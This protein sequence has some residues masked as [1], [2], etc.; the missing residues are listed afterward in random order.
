MVANFISTYGNLAILALMH[1]FFLQKRYIPIV[2]CNLFILFCYALGV[3]KVF[4]LEMSSMLNIF[5]ITMHNRRFKISSVVYIMIISIGC[6]LLALKE[7]NNDLLI[8]IYDNIYYIN[9]HINIMNDIYI[10]VALLLIVGCIPFGDWIMYLFS[11]SSSLFKVIIFITPMFLMFNILYDYSSVLDPQSYQIFGS[12]ICVYSCFCII[13]NKNLRLILVNVITYFY[14]IQII[15]LSKSYNLQFFSNWLVATFVI[16]L[17]SNTIIPIR[18][19]KYNINNIKNILVG[20]TEKILFIISMLFLLYCFVLLYFTL[21][22]TRGL[23]KVVSI[24]LF[25]SFFAKIIASISFL[26]GDSLKNDN[27]ENNT[28]LFRMIRMFIGVVFLTG[29]CVY[30][31]KILKFF[32]RP[33]LYLIIF[34]LLI[35]SVVLVV[36][37]LFNNA[38]KPK[39]LKSKTYSSF[40]V[41]FIKFLKIIILIIQSVFVDFAKS[42]K[43]KVIN[44]AIS[45]VPQKLSNILYGKHLYFYI[46]FLIE[47]IIV[48]TIECVVLQ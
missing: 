14:G 37:L 41:N 26:N 18:T 30:N 22:E 24:S 21:P 42:V 17:L 6:F 27:K 16:L 28:N 5:A 11:I 7:L 25:T 48:L 46:F 44:L 34:S 2:L 29:Y 20:K 38:I 3:N 32:I 45:S 19:M 12:L 43:E 10:M 36:S 39:I 8:S 35:F 4:C 31:A 33:S 15:Y 47:V 23:L 9:K 40:V 13:F 1:L